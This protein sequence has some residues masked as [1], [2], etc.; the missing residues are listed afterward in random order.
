MIGLLCTAV[1]EPPDIYIRSPAAYD[2]GYVQL[3]RIPLPRTPVDKGLSCLV[4]RLTP[5]PGGPSPHDDSPPY[6]Y[7]LAYS[8]PRAN[9]YHHLPQEAPRLHTPV[10]IPMHIAPERRALPPLQVRVAH[11]QDRS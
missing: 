10:H 11:N 4:C 3:R 6:G 1:Y 5:D 7:K 8:I 2:R 9:P